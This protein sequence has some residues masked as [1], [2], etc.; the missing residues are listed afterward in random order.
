MTDEEREAL[1]WS[2]VQIGEPDELGKLFG[3]SGA[4]I[5]YIMSGDTWGWLVQPEGE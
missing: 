5:G 3:V 1:F 4:T 2:K